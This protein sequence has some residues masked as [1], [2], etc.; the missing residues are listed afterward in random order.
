MRNYATKCVTLN[1][2]LVFQIIHKFLVFLHKL[3]SWNTLSVYEELN[4]IFKKQYCPGKC[5]EMK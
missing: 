1:H 5:S 2:E 4:F 3:Y